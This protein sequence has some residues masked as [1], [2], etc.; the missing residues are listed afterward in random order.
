MRR[1]IH[2]DQVIEDAVE[3]YRVQ[4]GLASWSQ[5]AYA[6]LTIGLQWQH[7]ETARDADDRN[8]VNYD[9][10]DAQNDSDP[11]H[12]ALLPQWGGKREGSGRKPDGS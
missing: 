7:A 6:L 3:A 1:T 12:Q 8:P 11:F 10:F 4:H 9:P 5:A 2:T